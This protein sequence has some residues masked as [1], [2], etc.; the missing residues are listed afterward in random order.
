MAAANA[1]GGYPPPGGQPGGQPGGYVSFAVASG[2]K[3]STN[4]T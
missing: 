1:A 4:V 2:S 3:H